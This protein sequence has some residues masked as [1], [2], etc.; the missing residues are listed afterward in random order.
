MKT[1]TFRIWESNKM[2]LDEL[3]DM[4]EK[5]RGQLLSRN[6]IINEALK[7]LKENEKI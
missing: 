1:T 5:K 6:L 2:L 4:L 7:N 3:R